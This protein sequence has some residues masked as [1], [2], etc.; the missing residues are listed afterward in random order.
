MAAE[1]AVVFFAAF[2]F[3]AARFL[4]EEALAT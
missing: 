1:Q 3:Y 2:T 4:H